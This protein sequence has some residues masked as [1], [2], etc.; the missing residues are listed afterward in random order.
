MADVRPSPRREKSFREFGRYPVNETRRHSRSISPIQIGCSSES[1]NG[2]QESE[3]SNVRH[4]ARYRVMGNERRGRCFPRKDS[5]TKEIEE[6]V[7]R[8]ARPVPILRLRRFLRTLF[9]G[10]VSD[11]D[12]INSGDRERAISAR[13][14]KDDA[15]R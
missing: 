1:G 2:K 3:R 14:T 6:K 5:A 12:R 15:L 9:P 4:V 11:A 10:K 8:V 7:R 13:S